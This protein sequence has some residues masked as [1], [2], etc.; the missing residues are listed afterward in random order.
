[1]IPVLAVVAG[2][3]MVA[4]TLK[5][6]AGRMLRTRRQM[7]TLAG[8]RDVVDAIAREVAA[9]ARPLEA[10]EH[11]AEGLKSEALRH[12]VDVACVKVRLGAAPGAGSGGAAPGEGTGGTAPGSDAP[13]SL[14]HLFH[15]WGISHRHGVGLA[16]LAR[17]HVTDID[18]QLAHISKSTSATA[19]AR[20][21]V[22][23][24]LALPI[25]AVALGQSSGLGTLTFLLTN[26]LGVLLFLTGVGLVCAGTLWTEHLSESLTASPLGGVGVRAGPAGSTLVGPL[27]AA[28]ALDVSAAALRAGKA[29]LPAWD[30]G[31][32]QLVHDGEHDGEGD[33][34]RAIA[35]LNLGGGKDAWLTLAEHSLFGPIAR[36]AAQQTR[37]GTSLADG[38]HQQ[39]E[40]LRRV[41]ADKA[42][43]GAE[44]V[45][46]ALAAPLTL[47][48]LPA[49]VFV[50]L[51]P[52]AIGMASL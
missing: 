31:V 37:A 6:V 49:F 35:L 17:A 16:A 50:G 13:S 47:C 2:A 21:T 42:T 46:I 22:T 38:M 26:V 1:M 44:K 8:V 18:A 30:V 9:G 3:L 45:L 20:L 40:H 7:K 4:F 12:E 32:G 48:F 28:R 52:L 33:L 25:G 27:D 5:V 34:G 14:A 41:A 43:A 51:I 15:I 10:V 23:V 11:A 39:A 36:Q 19:G 24:L 29:L